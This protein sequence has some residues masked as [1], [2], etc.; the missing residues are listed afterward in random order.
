MTKLIKLKLI[1]RIKLIESPRRL[2][3]QNLVDLDTANRLELVMCISRPET[4]LGNSLL[5]VVDHCRTKGGTR[6]LRANIL[7]PY[8]CL[9]KIEKRLSC[10][11][12]L[13]DNPILFCSLEVQRR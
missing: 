7:Q 10:V 2:K 4:N 13:V 1:R 3:F 9:S 11:K 12:E 6:L 8:F 5:G